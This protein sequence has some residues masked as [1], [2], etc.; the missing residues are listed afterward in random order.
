MMM[1]CVPVKLGDLPSIWHLGIWALIFCCNSSTFFI[2]VDGAEIIHEH[3]DAESVIAGEDAVEQR[4]LP[5]A[6]EAG[7]H[8]HGS[9]P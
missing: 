3:R 8:G 6:E 2:N 5:R 9:D 4:R 1:D 7:E